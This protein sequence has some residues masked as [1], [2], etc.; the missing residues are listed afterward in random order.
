MKFSKKLFRHGGSLALVVPSE[1][2][3]LLSSD[4]VTIEI[5]ADEENN[6]KL[7][8]EPTSELDSIENDPLFGSFIEAIYRDA[9][10]NP[11]KLKDV[12]DVFTDRVKKLIEGVDIDEN[13]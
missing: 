8:V 10:E 13:E 9:M 12:S 4:N 3:Q 5:M 6:P 11:D 1:F 2:A 7:I